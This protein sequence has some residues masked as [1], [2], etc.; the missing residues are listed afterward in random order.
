MFANFYI[1]LA[2]TGTTQ[3]DITEAGCSN[4]TGECELEYAVTTNLDVSTEDIGI[5][6]II[7]HA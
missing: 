4:T 3:V 6:P 2:C 1:V 7:I 5:Y